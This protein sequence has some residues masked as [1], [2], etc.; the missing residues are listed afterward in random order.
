MLDTDNQYIFKVLNN[1]KTFLQRVRNLIDF[2]AGIVQKMTVKVQ[3][4]LI[5]KNVRCH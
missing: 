4:Y 5:K 1:Q 2:L 3:H